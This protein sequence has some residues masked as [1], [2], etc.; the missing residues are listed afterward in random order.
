[1][2]MDIYNASA[3][4]GKTYTLT[5]KYLQWL[6]AEQQQQPQQFRHLLAV[7]FTN[8]AAEEMKSR[9]L[10]ALN[11]LVLN[12]NS[13]LAKELTK[14]LSISPK[15]LR[16]RATRLQTAI[17]H[18][19]SHFAVATID[20]FF[21]KIIRAF[22][23]EAGLLPGF[24]VE[25]DNER[26]ID[27]SIERLLQQAIDD[28]QLK[29]W[30]SKRIEGRIEEGRNWDI[31][32]ELREIGKQI[33]KE[34]FQQLV[35][36]FG[37]Y[38]KDK[39]FLSDYVKELKI[40]IKNFEE[41]LCNCSQ[42][43]L[44]LLQKHELSPDDFKGK[45]RSFVN[46]FHN[47]QKGKYEPGAASKAVDNLDEWYGK[48]KLKNAT[49]DTIY[50]P[51]NALLRKTIDIYSSNIKDYNTAQ[52]ILKNVYGMG[53][54]ADMANHITAISVEENCLSIND[55]LNLLSTLIGESD[56]PFVYEKTGA[57][58][59]FF[60]IDEFQDTS[61]MQWN[62]LKPLLENSMSGGG[63]TMVVGDVKQSIYRWRNGDWDIL[64][65]KINED[66]RFFDREHHYL[67]T[68]W[69]SS[70]AVV[71]FNNRLFSGL[72]QMLQEELNKKLNENKISDTEAHLH[73]T[74]ASAYKNATQQVAPKHSCKE[75]Y[76]Y[77]EKITGNDELKAFDEALQRLPLLVKEL[78]ERGYHSSDIALLVRKNKEG[79]AVANVLL[80]HNF[81][82][83][84]QDS[85]F[86]G[87]SPAVQ[88]I[89]AILYHSVY[90]N[91][92]I[93]QIIINNYLH[94]LKLKSNYEAEMDKIAQYSLVEAIE[95]IIQLFDFSQC[96]EDMP[97]VQEL[98]DIILK[99]TAKETNDIYSFIEW[100]QANG[101]EKT[102]TMSDEQD[103][104]RILTI[105]KSKG[106]EFRIAIVPF[107]SWGLEQKS[108]ELLWVGCE[109]APFNKIPYLPLSYT[110]S[111]ADTHFRDDYF[112]EKVNSYIDN[113]NVLY[114]ALTRAEDE[115]Y[116][117]CPKKGNNN[118]NVGNALIELLQTEQLEVGIKAPKVAPTQRSVTQLQHFYDYPS[119]PYLNQL[120]LRYRDSA[121]R[122]STTRSLRDYGVL[123]HRAFSLINTAN[124][125]DKAVTTL[126]DEGFL[127]CDVDSIT[128]LTLEIRA[129]LAQPEAAVWFDGSRKVLSEINILLPD[130][131][132]GLH[133]LRPD[134]IMLHGD[135]VEVLD[136]KFGDKEEPEYEKQLNSY[137]ACLKAMG[138]VSVEGYLWY[139]NKGKVKRICDYAIKIQDELKMYL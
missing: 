97:F 43:A 27:E 44:L 5:R 4:S 109:Q 101:D 65:N 124:D 137:I 80:E 21:Q 37:Q 12:K 64:A 9:I 19:Y 10:K 120:R 121:E 75:G 88:F 26:L 122:E 84:S 29:K 25:L 87:R 6:L 46:Y 62:N 51:M 8:K 34:N 114:V 39:S 1:M 55:S 113:L 125:V 105:H 73:T 57:H 67:D 30:I 119:F 13:G 132:E 24:S 7:T 98:H 91:D 95:H 136:Y 129:A 49:I 96:P 76:V 15:E 108:G 104:I 115:L 82:I 56:T 123:M 22:M 58:Y 38:L 90:P 72:P 130:I 70:K 131:G 54:L 81:N 93:N 110:K 2:A 33:F 16:K 127:P 40:I 77:V 45:S 128:V 60:M 11:E 107:C 41:Q 63:N 78:L 138:Y 74:I 18:D 86:L 59:R 89:I 47:I 94:T 100:W 117:F 42:E 3:G 66:F 14:E 35:K 139:V 106:L 99:H 31:R 61:T 52:Q 69:R 23:H 83:I 118:N 32:Q 126:V 17:L 20:K 48:D 135:K 102:L 134:R 92:A 28:A 79:Q 50:A 36:N 116:V 71:E 112:T 68:N 53:L 103:A 85:L 133:Q 111:L